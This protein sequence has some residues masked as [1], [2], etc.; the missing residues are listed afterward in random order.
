VEPE[1]SAAIEV[2]HEDEAIVVL[3]KPAPLPMHAGGRFNRNTLQYIL[4]QVYYP[5]KPR[6]AHRRAS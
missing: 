1:V 3:N 6:P 5:Q 2:I 4:E